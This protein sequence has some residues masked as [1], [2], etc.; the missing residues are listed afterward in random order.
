MTAWEGGLGRCN[1]RK[2]LQPRGFQTASSSSQIASSSF[3]HLLGLGAWD[4][5]AFGAAL[6]KKSAIEGHVQMYFFILKAEFLFS[7]VGYAETDTR[8]RLLYPRGVVLVRFRP[9]AQHCFS[10]MTRTTSKPK[11][12]TERQVSGDCPFAR[13]SAVTQG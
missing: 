1:V 5:A 2:C 9:S 13:I 10:Q 6:V 12:S 11:T 7:Y 8:E 3:I 4:S